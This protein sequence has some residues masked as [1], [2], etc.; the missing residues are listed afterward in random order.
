M[1]DFEE[2]LA[3]FNDTLRNLRGNKFIDY[4]Q[5]GLKFKLYSCE[6]MFNRG[7][8][9]IY[10]KQVEQGMQDLTFASQEKAVPDHDVIDEALRERA[11]GYTVFSIPVGVVYR[12]NEAKVKNLRAK[13]Y[14]GKAKLVAAVD[15]SNAF[16]GFTGAEIKRQNTVR[17]AA[18]DD[19]PEA[20]ISYAASNLVKADLRSRNRQQSEPPPNRNMFPPTPPPDNDRNSHISNMNGPTSARSDFSQRST[21]PRPLDLSSVSND[22]TFQKPE[23]QRTASSENKSP[24]RSGRSRT[25]PAQERDSP[26][27]SLARK[28]S[29]ASTKSPGERSQY[30]DDYRDAYAR[31][32]K[33]GHSARP[34]PGYISEGDEDEAV[35]SYDEPDFEMMS[36]RS[37]T[38]RSRRSMPDIK[39]IRVK[40]HTEDTRYVMIGVEVQLKDFM[41]QIKNK[42]SLTQAFKV[43]IQDEGDMV[44]LGDQDDLEMAISQSKQDARKD[45]NDM[46]KMEVSLIGFD[47][48]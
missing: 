42:F 31:A 12:P 45:R 48:T 39:K 11:E 21:K 29:L 10:L 30:D 25:R 22:R 9:Y 36:V 46:G 20:S 19:R 18:K 27:S 41:E 24:Q 8:C 5:L 38:G 23:M 40:V 47:S 13:D 7:L 1:G 14:L 34:T 32:N 37:S 35:N 43:K 4:E 3:N 44:T 16:T 6:V 26:S 15:K 33:R 17:E 28:P 2:A